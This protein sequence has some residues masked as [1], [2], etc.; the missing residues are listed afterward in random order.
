V[1]LALKDDRVA[2][3]RA[4]GHVE[5]EMRHV[6]EDLVAGARGALP[7]DDASAPGALRTRVDVPA[8]GGARATTVVTQHA[9]L[10]HELGRF[11]NRQNWGFFFTFLKTWDVGGVR[12]MK[13]KDA[14]QCLH[15]CKYLLKKPQTRRRTWG[16]DGL[17]L[18]P[19]LHAKKG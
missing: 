6:L 3:G 10:D 8:R 14:R 17:D 18:A 15:P 4:A 9:L 16:H 2:L 7:H 11:W 13:R 5:R 1:A 12:G 19:G